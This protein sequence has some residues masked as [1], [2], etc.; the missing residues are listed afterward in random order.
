MATTRKTKINKFYQLWA[1]NHMEIDEDCDGLYCKV[2]SETEENKMY[3][4]RVD[5]SSVVP[6]VTSCNCIGHHEYGNTCKHMTICQDF[7]NRIYHSNA[8]KFEAKQEATRIAKIESE[9]EAVKAETEAHNT[10]EDLEKACEEL[11]NTKV[12]K[13]GQKGSADLAYKGNLNGNR[14]FVRPSQIAAQAS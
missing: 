4:V 6:T 9:V 2:I 7:Y 5:E 3:T 10:P 12:L 13:V 1:T 8:V 11:R 14:A